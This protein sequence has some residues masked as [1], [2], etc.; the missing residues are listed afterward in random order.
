MAWAAEQRTEEVNEEVVEVN[1]ESR[2]RESVSS[3][4]ETSDGDEDGEGS[5]C[6]EDLDDAERGV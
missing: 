1:D 6:E 2:Q 4:S 5:G 3:E